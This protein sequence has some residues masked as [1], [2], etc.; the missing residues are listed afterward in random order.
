MIWQS[1]VEGAYISQIHDMAPRGDSPQPVRGV[2]RLDTDGHVTLLLDSI[3]MPNGLTLSPD[4]TKLY[5]GC[6]DE[7]TPDMNVKAFQLFSDGSVRF[8]QTL[9]EFTPP[10]GPDG[11]TV[12]SDGCI[13]VAVRDDADPG[14]GVY[15]PD[16]LLL[17][18]IATPEVPSNVSFGRPPGDSI[19][20]VTAGRGLYR[21]ATVRKGFF[22]SRWPEHEPL[23]PE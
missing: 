6:F 20:Y 11:I 23:P 15:S 13:Y 12:D 17:D 21:I 14:V 7:Q 1:I 16:G 4:E 22:S 9:I 19:L 18:W 8:E 5:V 10:A 3:S 2:Y